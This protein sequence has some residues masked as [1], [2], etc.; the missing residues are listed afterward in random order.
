M[1]II[2]RIFWLFILGALVMSCITGLILVISKDA[3]ANN[4]KSLD[5]SAA[6]GNLV[7]A[8]NT[9]D[10][11]YFDTYLPDE[12]KAKNPKQVGYILN[13]TYGITS[14]K[15]GGWYIQNGETANVQLLDCSTGDV[16]A[17]QYF[18]AEFPETVV[19]EESK[20]NIEIE[21]S[22]VAEWLTHVY[23][24]WPADKAVVH[25]YGPEGCYICG[26]L[27]NE[28]AP[29]EPAATEPAT[30]PLSVP[31]TTT[32]VT[33]PP[34]KD[35]SAEAETLLIGQ[36]KLDYVLDGSTF[37]MVPVDGDIT[38]QINENHTATITTPDENYSYDWVYNVHSYEDDDPDKLILHYLL[39]DAEGNEIFFSYYY[40]DTIFIFTEE[41]SV[42]F[43]R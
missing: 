3:Y 7:T 29:T 10:D 1:K 38:F 32:T 20:E 11:I 6:T 5:P 25:D 27:P 24:E 43:A 37:D 9:N 33:E 31:E 39:F 4:M 22:V 36:W 42:F 34:Q 12:I 30:E 13:V 35:L 8:Y 19:I 18:E 21:P 17:S 2:R 40:D 28:S 41:Y 14:A 26:Q 16:I 15:Y 23:P